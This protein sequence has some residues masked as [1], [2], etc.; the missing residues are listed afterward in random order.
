MPVTA[1]HT[2]PVPVPAGSALPAG[3]TGPAGSAGPAAGGREGAAA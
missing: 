3:S 2:E 1:Q